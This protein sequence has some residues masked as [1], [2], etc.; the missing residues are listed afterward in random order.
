MSMCNSLEFA[1]YLHNPFDYPSELQ[2][3]CRENFIKMRKNDYSLSKSLK[4]L[5]N[6]PEHFGDVKRLHQDGLK[7]HYLILKEYVVK[8]KLIGLIIYGATILEKEKLSQRDIYINTYIS[9]TN[10]IILNVQ[11]ISRHFLKVH[12]DYYE[13]VDKLCLEALPNRM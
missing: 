13:E 1:S 5:Y 9:N 10:E 11:D 3:K 2:K 12:C 6:K 7:K 8:N 4:D